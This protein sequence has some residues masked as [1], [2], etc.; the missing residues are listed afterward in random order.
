M[1]CFKS[2]PHCGEPCQLEKGHEHQCYDGD[3]H[4]TSEDSKCNCTVCSAAKK[5]GYRNVSPFKEQPVF[6]RKDLVGK[7]KTKIWKDEHGYIHIE[8]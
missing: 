6:V 3:H 4:W 5:L 8:C 2:C 1:K 7:D